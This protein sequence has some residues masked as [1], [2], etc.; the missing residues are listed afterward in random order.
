MSNI[1][2][3]SCITLCLMYMTGIITGCSLIQKEKCV[4]NEQDITRFQC[5]GQEYIILNDTVKSGNLGD[6]IGYIHKLIVLDE[7]G[8]FLEQIDSDEKV[9]GNT[10]EMSKKYNNAAMI[11]F[12]NV[13]SIEDRETDILAVDI[14]GVYYRAVQA[15][16]FNVNDEIISIENLLLA[17]D[18]RKF[19]I[20]RANCTQLKRGDKIYQVTDERISPEDL[21]AY[22]DILADEVLFNMN[23][24]L[25]ISKDEQI[26]IDWTGNDSKQNQRESW[27]Y[28]SIY[29]I[30]EIDIETAVAVRINNEY[31]KA[32]VLH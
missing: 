3:K 20:N 19:I 16:D 10:M 4:V 30:K 29:E 23:T 8:N 26:V 13:F 1:I 17:V 9:I 32:E 22:I 27:F 6:W 7:S 5:D 15:D 28:E 2:K 11:S 14:N 31:R 25:P 24:K 12:L 18:K 21:G